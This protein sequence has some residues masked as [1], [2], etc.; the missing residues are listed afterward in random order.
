MSRFLAISPLLGDAPGRV[1]AAL[2]D[3]WAELSP[4]RQAEYRRSVEAG[5]GTGPGGPYAAWRLYHYCLFS[6]FL[7]ARLRFDGKTVFEFGA[8]L[9]PWS[10][11]RAARSPSSVSEPLAPGL[12]LLQR[13]RWRRD[14]WLEFDA[15]APAA[16]VELG[17]ALLDQELMPFAIQF[18]FFQSALRDQRVINQAEYLDVSA[19][20][21]IT[22]SLQ[23]EKPVTLTHF[24]FQ[25]LHIYFEL[26]G[27]HRSREITQEIMANIHRH[28]KKGDALIQVTPLSYVVLS[29]GARRD[30]IVER[31]RRIYFQ[32]RSLVLEYE[33][34]LATVDRFPVRLNEIWQALRL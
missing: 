21:V 22:E 18:C 14:H 13:E 28:L 6:G 17:E 30:Q 34:F 25:S 31:F 27:E 3:V 23:R 26:S 7:Q 20:A 1:R 4:E 12:G 15:V 32:I 10:E 9:A 11:D 33:I 5:P 29:P 24:R 8:R 16:L 2:D 19:R